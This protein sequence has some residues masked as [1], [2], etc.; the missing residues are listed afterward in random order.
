VDLDLTEAQKALRDQARKIAVGDLAQRAADIDRAQR[1]PTENLKYLAKQGMLGLTV[2]KE[3]GGAGLDMVA[4]VVAVEELAS[5]CA[6]TAAIAG[7]QNLLVCEP[8]VRFGS[9]AQKRH[10]LPSLVNGAKLGCFALT[11]IGADASLD[12]IGTL[13]RRSGDGWIL[14]G[15]KPFVLC[16]PMAQVALIFAYTSEDEIALSAFLV[17]TESTGISF[18][19]SYDKMGLRGA[20]TTSMTLEDVRVPEAALLGAEGTGHEV[21]HFSHEGGRIVTAALSIGIAQ[22][23]FSEATRYAITRQVGEEPLSQQQTIQFKLAEMSTQIDAARMLTWRA[24]CSRDGSHTTGAQ[25]SM[26]KL[27]ATEAASRVASDAFQVLGNHGCL[28]N[29]GVERHFRDAKVVEILDGTSEIQRL[30]IAS[31]LL[32]D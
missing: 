9:E 11:E 16:G 19:P 18:G 32:K 6:S 4:M 31:I 3:Y 28:S 22:A 10:W 17:P 30:G 20:I 14:N 13:A 2:P 15:K 29:F 12:G 24:A 1:F 7:L 23:A 26:A 27:V 25:A 5:A 8:I 21:L